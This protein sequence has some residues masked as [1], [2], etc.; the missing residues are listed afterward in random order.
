MQNLKRLQHDEFLIRFG[1]TWKQG[2]HVAI[3]GSTG[4]GKTTVAQEIED[5]RDY[6]VVIATKANDE[7][8]DHYTRFT[9]MDKWPPD[10]TKKLVL[11]WKKP[12]VLGDFREQRRAIYGV[13]ADVFKVG[14]WTVYFDDLFYVSETLRLKESVRMFYTQV[15]SNHV[16]IV[17]SIQRPFWVPIEALS[18]STYVLLFGTRDQR[19]IKRVSEG[20]SIPIQELQQAISQLE[21]YE[22]LF[23]QTGKTPILIE[24]RDL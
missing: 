3:V 8:L 17:S 12:K 23:L 11:F 24:K 5:L 21:E 15:R 13:M 2:Q 18:Q 20:I 9:K 16:S 1:K 7:S 19:D 4:S 6:V 10:Y 14:G 22:F